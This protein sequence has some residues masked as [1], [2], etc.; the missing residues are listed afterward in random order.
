MLLFPTGEKYLRMRIKIV[1][2]VQ[3]GRMNSAFLVF[4]IAL[5]IFLLV[6]VWSCKKDVIP[7]PLEHVLYHSEADAIRTVMEKPDAYE[8]QIIFT[9]I[10]RSDGGI[11]FINHHFRLNANNYF[12]P[13][14]TVKLPI[15]ALALER[16]AEM[17]LMDLD[18]RFYVE[19][20]SLETTMAREVIKVFALSDNEAS[21]RMIE[22]MGQDYINERLT[23]L[24][25]GPVRIAHRLSVPD[26]D[27]VTTRPVIVYIN[28]STT[29]SISPTVNQEPKPLNINGL[30]KGKAFMDDEMLIKE[31]FDFSL[32]NYY[33]LE[34]Q[35]EVMKRIIFPDL[36]EEPEKFKMD[37]R[38]REH[39]LTAMWSPPRLQG[40]N[41]DE[42][43]DSYGKFFIY[44]DK[45]TQ[46]PDHLRIYN[47]VG[48]AYG[49]L[50]D[51][52]YI[53]DTESDVEFLLSATIL[54]NSDGVFNDDQY[55]YD[56][57][58]IPF[59]ASLGRELYHLKLKQKK[60]SWKL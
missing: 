6:P 22:L 50:T 57:I 14:S 9:E 42:Y 56:E 51:C 43:C 37:E 35:H 1:S 31:P 16:I 12:Y 18:T 29:T 34:T 19:G 39:L 27:D 45:E 5:L 26:A 2:D 58:G 20:D 7:D 17:D 60:A 44:G 53:L 10:D 54:V 28:D 4:K 48:Y 30:R 52:A 40:Y 38:A 36:F 25:A 13:A 8:V 49:T 55:E 32:K 3:R 23:L 46:I 24:N 33:P 11:K 21:N 59:L 47:K 15:A 41:A